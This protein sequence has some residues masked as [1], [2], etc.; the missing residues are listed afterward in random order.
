MRRSFT[1]TKKNGAVAIKHHGKTM[2]HRISLKLVRAWLVRHIIFKARDDVAFQHL[3]QAWI[4]GLAHRK[5]WLAVHGV[6]PLLG[7]AVVL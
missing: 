3:Q 4:D 2:K 1:L 5:K 7:V 6:D